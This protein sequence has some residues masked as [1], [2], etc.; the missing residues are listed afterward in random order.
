MLYFKKE[1]G[2]KPELVYLKRL[3]LD[4]S[5]KTDQQRSKYANERNSIK[6]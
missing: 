1:S 2:A 4:E 3:F 6:L 5:I